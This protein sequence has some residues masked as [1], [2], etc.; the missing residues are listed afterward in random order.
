MGRVRRRAQPPLMPSSSD[1]IVPLP[2]LSQSPRTLDPCLNPGSS[3]SDLLGISYPRSTG[4]SSHPTVSL[5]LP[6]PSLQRVI[7]PYS[8][9]TLTGIQPIQRDLINMPVT[10]TRLLSPPGTTYLLPTTCRYGRPSIM[11]TQETLEFLALRLTELATCQ[12]LQA[13]DQWKDMC[14]RALT[15]LCT[16]EV[17]VQEDS[18]WTRAAQLSSITVSE[19]SSGRPLQALQWRF[20]RESFLR[21][22]ITTSFD[23]Y[24]RLDWPSYNFIVG[25]IQRYPDMWLGWHC[26]LYPCLRRFCP[27][28][29]QY[30]FLS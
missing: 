28:Q 29:F 1:P 7:S 12:H 13:R 27:L 9:Q 19:S 26:Y 3:I 25:W 10:A 4:S 21:L 16:T 24:Y 14:A 11:I 2:S 6:P 17:M 18:G 22:G 15:L 30:M 20:R 23:P 8:Y 5:P